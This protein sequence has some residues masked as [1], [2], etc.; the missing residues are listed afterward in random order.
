MAARKLAEW[1]IFHFYMSLNR[2][3][4]SNNIGLKLVVILKKRNTFV[5]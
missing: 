3:S 2:T 1:P 4:T 5:T